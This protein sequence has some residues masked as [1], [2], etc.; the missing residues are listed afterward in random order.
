LN[1]NADGGRKARKPSGLIHGVRE[2]NIG[3]LRGIDAYS[4]EEK[5]P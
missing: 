2:A 3:P 1:K 5:C 4:I